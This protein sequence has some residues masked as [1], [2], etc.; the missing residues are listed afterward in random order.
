MARRA[1]GATLTVLLAS[2][3]AFLMVQGVPGDAALMMAGT[4]APPEVVEG[5]RKELGLDAPVPARLAA[6]L[7]RALTGD[8][9]VSVRYHRPV[10]ELLWQHFRVNLILVALAVPLAAA[11][12][13]GMGA[14]AA[15]GASG[16]AGWGAGGRLLKWEDRALSWVMQLGLSV[17][18]FWLAMIL[19]WVAAVRLHAFPAVA[20]VGSGGL[21]GWRG[22]VLPAL[23]LALPAGCAVG[24][25]V[26]AAL[27]QA[28][29]EPYVQAARGKGAGLA[30]VVWRHALVG[31]LNP[32]ASSLG[33][34]V[35][36]LLTGSLIVETV[37]G[38]PGVGRIMLA[39]V[40]FRDLALVS[41]GA[42]FAAVVVSFSSAVV[43]ALY[44][45]L[46][47]RVQYR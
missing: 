10:G 14:L 9:G 16:A 40:E 7:G 13:L 30:R 1:A 41:G 34:L 31:A 45:L 6:W 24:L 43:D 28:L 18:S 19:I 39:G 42:A 27:A 29:E 5:L 3:A 32:V 38:L 2:S 8:L 11:L 12:A 36:E 15:V 37:F 4:D 25:V 33:L 26:R 21:P 17:P 44:G 23:A 46:D 35:A 47:P 22:F 20:P